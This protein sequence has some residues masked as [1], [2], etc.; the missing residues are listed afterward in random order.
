MYKGIVKTFGKKAVVIE[1]KKK[2]QY[3]ALLNEVDV[4]ITEH[5]NYPLLILP[6]KFNVDI[7]KH[8]GRT[9]IGLRYYATNVELDVEF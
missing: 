6:V 2:R 7:N 5:L 3:Y 4:L 1:D 8:S 9:F